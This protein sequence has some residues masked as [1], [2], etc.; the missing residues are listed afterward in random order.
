MI[1]STDEMIIFHFIS[2]RPSCLT[3]LRNWHMLS[4]RDTRISGMKQRNS[5]L[6]C[7]SARFGSRLKH[8]AVASIK[9]AP[10]LD[11]TQMDTIYLE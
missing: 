4:Y 3:D 10:Q 5:A 6:D 2:I 7:A 9:W 1:H 8:I 11:E